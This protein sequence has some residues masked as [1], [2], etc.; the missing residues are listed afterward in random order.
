VSCWCDRELHGRL[1][2]A[3]AFA[4]TG[5]SSCKNSAHVHCEQPA[6]SQR[7]GTSEEACAEP[8]S[9]SRVCCALLFVQ[10]AVVVSSGECTCSRVS[11]A[12]VHSTFNC[13]SAVHLRAAPGKGVG[14]YKTDLSC[15]LHLCSARLGGGAGQPAGVGPRRAPAC[16]A[17]AARLQGICQLP[18]Q[19][20]RSEH[21]VH[22]RPDPNCGRGPAVPGFST[23]A[24]HVLPL[25]QSS[26]RALLTCMQP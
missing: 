10:L 9:R 23:L 11:A 1:S 22:V 15:I 24:M 7:G 17:R 4:S 26:R 6:R 18:V 12:W 25:V 13:G 21:A 19:A 16:V 20:R 2:K 3:G 5:D 8:L 14:A